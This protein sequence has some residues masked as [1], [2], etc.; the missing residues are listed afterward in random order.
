[1][2]KKTTSV[3]QPK[4]R[5]L[6]EYVLAKRREACAVCALPDE[7]RAQ[8]REK[9][10]ERRVIRAWLLADYG[11]DIPDSIFTTH[12]AAHHEERAD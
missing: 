12:S 5:S 9:K 7:V 6:I 10:Y 11:M 3:A 1:M 2:A 4:G 8:L